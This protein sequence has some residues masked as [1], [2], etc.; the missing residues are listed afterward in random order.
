MQ[1][2]IKPIIVFSI[3]IGTFWWAYE[4]QPQFRRFVESYGHFG[5]LTTLEAKYTAE[6]IMRD[7]KKELL[8]DKNHTYQEPTLK[9]HPH[10][11]FEVKFTEANKSPKEG[12]V[13]WSLVDGEIVLNTDTW[14]KTH[15]FQDAIQA[16]ATRADFAIMNA[17]AKA[18]G[19]MTREQLLKELKVDQ[20]TLD[21]WIDS[22]RKKHLLFQKGNE[23]QLH[24]QN[25][26]LSVQP[27]TTIK[28]S[29]VKKSGLQTSRERIKYDQKQIERIA[30]A[31]FGQDF[32]VRD[33]KTV[34]L[35][36]YSIDVLNPDGSILTSD[37]NALNGKRIF[38][39]YLGG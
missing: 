32:T 38:P 5:D 20:D 30:S 39:T 27:Q 19:S 35:P 22:S 26:K 4:N 18:R 16:S 21:L 11:L 33:V 7:H 8:I 36:V 37:W 9:F 10:L 15:G 1:R 14:E 25:P 13:L 6:Q 29:F 31:A 24:L 23:I 34:F 12:V 28:R 2:I 17:L 3:A